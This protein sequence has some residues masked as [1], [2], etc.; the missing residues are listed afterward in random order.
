MR[1]LVGVGLVFLCLGLSGCSL[2]GKKNSTADASSRTGSGSG[3]GA[4]TDYPVESSGPAPNANGL[5]AG[6]VQ[7][8]D[9]RRRP[10]V[11][12]QVVD[13]QDTKSAARIEVE[14]D[15]EGYFTIQGLQPGRHYQLTARVKDGDRLFSGTALV[16][17]PNPRL[18][19]VMSDD[20]RLPRRRRS[21]SRPRCLKR[22]RARNLAAQLPPFCRPR[23]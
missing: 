7:D 12:I 8:A 4:R 11:M 20:L 19:I 17:P 22:T 6:Q 5:L 9:Y 23:R 14:A 18:S 2:F 16:T 1:T 15:K 10:G 21:R 13:L 3:G